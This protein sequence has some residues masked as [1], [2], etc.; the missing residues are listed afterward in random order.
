M[1]QTR[2]LL[3]RFLG[4]V[5]FNEN[6]HW[7]WTGRPNNKGYGRIGR[8]G[9]YG[10]MQFAHRA[11]YELFLGRIPEGLEID[12]VCRVTMCVNPDHLEAVTHRENL[13][14]GDTFTRKQLA[15]THCP[16]GHP[17]DEENTYISVR[18]LRYCRTCVRVA[19]RKSYRKRKARQANDQVSTL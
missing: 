11:A 19:N 5:Q 10:G 2:P 4:H 12:H 6:G 14:R 18:G 15:K 16:Q 1:I 9:K 7:I 8:G 3:E 13:R 17:Y